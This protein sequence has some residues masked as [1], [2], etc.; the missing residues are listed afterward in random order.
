MLILIQSS[1]KEGGSIVS[2]NS[3]DCFRENAEFELYLEGE[4]QYGNI[5]EGTGSDSRKG[6]PEQ[7]LRGGSV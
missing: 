2:Q 7:N 1:S 4:I 5:K 6:R 3:K